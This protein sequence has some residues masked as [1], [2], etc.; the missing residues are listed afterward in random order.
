MRH[1]F[2]EEGK[3]DWLN[4]PGLRTVIV[5]IWGM[6]IVFELGHITRVLMQISAQLSKARGNE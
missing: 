5:V 2:Q 3:M 6:A 4:D 1:Y